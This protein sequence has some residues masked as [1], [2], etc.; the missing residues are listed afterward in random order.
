[1]KAAPMR[2]NV[3]TH[4]FHTPCLLPTRRLRG[5]LRHPAGMHGN[6]PRARHALGSLLRP[7]RVGRVRVDRSVRDRPVGLPHPQPDVVQIHHH[8][9]VRPT[10]TTDTADTTDASTNICRAHFSGH[11]LIARACQPTPLRPSY[12]IGSRGFGRCSTAWR[13]RRIWCAE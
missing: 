9:A 2:W 4:E 1:M 13:C 8:L 6:L 7:R 11:V 10:N 12:P 3:F 5:D